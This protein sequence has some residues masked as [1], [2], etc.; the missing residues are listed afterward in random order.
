MAS[1][2]AESSSKLEISLYIMGYDAYIDIWTPSFGD[3][4]L[5]IREETNVHDKYAVA[6]VLPNK[7]VVG[8]VPYN[9]APIFSQ[10][11]R[12]G[13]NEGTVK[14]TGERVN[15]GAGY[16]LEVPCVYTIYGPTAYTERAKSILQE[17]NLEWY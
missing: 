17:S 10:F 3:C 7:T 11:L 15:R 1:Q 2:P 8:H 4:L 16:G 5:L 14:V 9:L 6:V 13:F 12:K